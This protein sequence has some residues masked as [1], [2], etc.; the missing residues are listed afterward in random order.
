MRGIKKVINESK[1][2]LLLGLWFGISWGWVQLFCM[3]IL[4]FL[5]FDVNFIT[6][7]PWF[8]I[9]TGILAFVFIS[10]TELT[11]KHTEEIINQ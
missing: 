1:K 4:Y 3:F 2:I 7:N 6:A 10:S 11:R 5:N 9:V 8:K